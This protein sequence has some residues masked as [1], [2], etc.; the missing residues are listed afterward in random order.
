M[1]QAARCTCAGASS[2]LLTARWLLTDGATP[3]QRP[4]VCTQGLSVFAKEIWRAQA[5]RWLSDQSFTG[6]GGVLARGDGAFLCHP[7][8]PL[9]PLF[10]LTSE[11]LT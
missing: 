5:G 4:Q 10:S 1:V 6:G 7:V 11:L 2:D 3:L 8:H 9:L